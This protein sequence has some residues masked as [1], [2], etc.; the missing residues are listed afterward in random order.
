MLRLVHGLSH[1]RA[2][3]LP[4]GNTQRMVLQR[5]TLLLASVAA[6][7]MDSS[8]MTGFASAQDDALNDPSPAAS[9]A[10][11]STST[12]AEKPAQPPLTLMEILGELDSITEILDGEFKQR[13]E[14]SAKREKNCHDRGIVL[15]MDAGGVQAEVNATR[16]RLVALNE[17]TERVLTRQAMLESKT[18]A[19]TSKVNDVGESLRLTENDLVDARKLQ[20]SSQ[21][22]FTSHRMQHDRNKAIVDELIGYVQRSKES[23]KSLKEAV[24]SLRLL[25]RNAGKGVQLRGKNMMKGAPD[26]D[27][28]GYW[29]PPTRRSETRNPQALIEKESIKPEV[30]VLESSKVIDK[31][32]EAERSHD[33]LSSLLGEIKQ[34]FED[35]A[36]ARESSHGKLQES[37]SALVSSLETKLNRLENELKR[38]RQAKLEAASQL[39]KVVTS[40]ESASGKAEHES[41]ILDEL[42]LHLSRMQDH[43]AKH[44][45]ACELLEQSFEKC[46]GMMLHE[47]KT[48]KDIKTM[49]GAHQR[50]RA[51]ATAES[52]TNELA[53]EGAD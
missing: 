47:L 48:V 32:E 30:P 19:L 22:T 4:K 29:L 50:N 5:G 18:S 44:E 52:L 28:S 51:S 13:R 35:Y 23:F 1:F 40:I 6:I 21:S 14:E 42:K 46:K 8:A 2:L 43:I 33:K 39:R 26:Q 38:L 34:T 7:W 3:L 45:E 12:P 41:H 11:G 36:P 27:D 16:M 37:H 9:Q 17:E 25:E 15:E 10:S 53:S 49:L 31:V 24:P 20:A